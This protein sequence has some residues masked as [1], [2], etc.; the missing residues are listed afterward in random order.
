MGEPITFPSSTAV[1]RLPLLFSG[2]AQK[3]FFINQGFVVLDALVP[4][5]VDAV[6]DGPPADPEEGSC[7]LVGANPTGE[8]VARNDHLAVRV[9]DAWHFVEP[10]TG[11]EIYDRFSQRKLVFLS[12]WSSAPAPSAPVG[13]VIVDSEA[14][15]TLDELMATLKAIGILAE[16]D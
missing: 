15:A 2:Q 13:G 5:A 12:G 10:A 16:P 1:A 9:A 7:Y 4:R 6:L 14:R 11:M 8:W 3:E